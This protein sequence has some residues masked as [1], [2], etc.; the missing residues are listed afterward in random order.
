MSSIAAAQRTLGRML[1]PWWLLLVTDIGWMLVALIVLRFDYTLVSASAILFDRSVPVLLVKI[2]H[3]P[4]H[5]GA[6]HAVRTLGRVGVPVYAITED[7]FEPTALSRYLR[8]HFVWRTTG[9]EE[10]GEL[11]HGLRAITA[12]FDRPPIVLATDDEA[13]VLLAEHSNTGDF[14]APRVPSWLPRALASKRGLY[15][16]CKKV[17]VSTPDAVVPSSKDEVLAYAERGVFPVVLKNIEPWERLRTPAVSSST[18]VNT[19]EEL[20]LLAHEWPESPG[21]MFQEYLPRDTAEDWIFHGYCDA[22]SICL[23]AFTGIKLRSWPPH[24]GVTVHGRTVANEPLA[25]LSTN[26]CRQLGYQGIADL[27]WRFDR[28]DGRYKLLDFNPRVGAQFYLFRTEAGIDVVRAL[29]LDLTG[30]HVPS[31]RQIEGRGLVVENLYAVAMFSRRRSAE[32][33]ALHQRGRTAFA[34]I[35]RDD[36][37]PFLVMAIRFTGTAIGRATRGRPRRSPQGVLPRPLVRSASASVIRWAAKGVPQTKRRRGP[38]VAAAD[39][40]VKKSPGTD[41]SNDAESPG[42]PATRFSRLTRSGSRKSFASRFTR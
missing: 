20:M 32:Q 23:T 15:E 12:R 35:A 14:V 8:G 13:A 4:L 27:D 16:L 7:H 18:I 34:W 6:V 5:H 29:H 30:R 11:I 41:D 21:L 2:G 24:A 31:S 38:N 17:G 37:L 9:F 22:D 10:E 40:P 33:P 19:P 26:L 36:P 3:Y 28:R 39:R 42:E 25:E 1:P